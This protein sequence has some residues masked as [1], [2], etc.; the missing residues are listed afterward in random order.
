MMYPELDL[1]IFMIRAC[2]YECVWMHECVFLALL[3]SKF[4]RMIAQSRHY[5]QG[6]RYD[7]VGDLVPLIK[8]LVYYGVVIIE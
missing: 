5:S 6:K 1:F 2:P 7:S 8:S 3:P 4:P